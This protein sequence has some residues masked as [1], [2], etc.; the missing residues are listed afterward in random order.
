MILSYK[1]N[2][3]IIKNRYFQVIDL[4]YSNDIYYIKAKRIVGQ[5]PKL[6]V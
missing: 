1:K 2:A 5:I 3:G 4:K 6:G